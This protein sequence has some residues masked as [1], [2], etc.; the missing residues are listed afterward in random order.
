MSAHLVEENVTVTF[1]KG[2][3]LRVSLELARLATQFESDIHVLWNEQTVSLKSVISVLALA[4]G[5]G[6]KVR[7]VAKG[8][9]AQEAIQSIVNYIQEGVD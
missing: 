2:L 6:E 4:V 9:D 3:H 8:P 5:F 1:E 7:I